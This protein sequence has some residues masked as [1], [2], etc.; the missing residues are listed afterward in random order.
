MSR[1]VCCFYPRVSHRQAVTASLLLVCLPWSYLGA[2]C[3]RADSAPRDYRLD[4][5]VSNNAPLK[6]GIAV[7]QPAY[8][9]M[10]IWLRA[11]SGLRKMRFP[12]SDVQYPYTDVPGDF[13]NDHV[14]VKFGNQM[15]TP[16]SAATSVESY[17]GSSVWPTTTYASSWVAPGEA[18]AEALPLHLRFRFDRPG[19][20]SVR[21]SK[22]WPPAHQPGKTQMLV[23]QSN[24]VNF[25]VSNPTEPQREAWLQQ[26]LSAVPKDDASLL[27][28]YLPSILAASPDSRVLDLLLE[29]IYLWAH[30]GRDGEA[31]F[32]EGPAG[33]YSAT[34][35]FLFFPPQQVQS[36]VL[37]ALQDRGPNPQL[38]HVLAV[39]APVFEAVKDQVVSATLPYLRSKDQTQV[40]EAIVTLSNLDQNYKWGNNDPSQ[41]RFDE[42]V[43]AAAPDLIRSGRTNHLAVYLGGLSRQKAKARALLWQI[44]DQP[45]WQDQRG[46][47][48]DGP[49]QALICLTWLA[50]KSDLPRLGDMLVNFKP[51]K[52]ERHQALLYCLTDRL[53]E[54]YGQ[55][56]VP[57]FQR[58]LRESPYGEV[59]SACKSA[60]RSRYRFQSGRS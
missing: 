26:T 32:N 12:F 21:W 14:E 49:E 16:L 45:K 8:V 20:Y 30:R 53:L 31:P 35:L 38:S 27:R 9:G 39:H 42:A 29:Q 52:D 44:I 17:R 23:A 56:A 48:R 18:V 10:P 13:G 54:K 1:I 37:K 25:A 19:T 51:S 47:K 50:D 34:A 43:F 3:P 60:L 22:R 28:R 36:A 55:A 6:F 5:P 40:V 57:Y 15:L 59:R 2:A 24:W 41:L 4:Q 11:E 46:P 7:E 33:Q 58:A